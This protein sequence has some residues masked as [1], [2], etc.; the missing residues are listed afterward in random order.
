MNIHYHMESLFNPRN[1]IKHL[2]NTLSK[3][4][5]STTM[6][7]TLT[8]IPG[9]G[10]FIYSLTSLLLIYVGVARYFPTTIPQSTKHYRS[11]DNRLFS[12]SLKKGET[13]CLGNNNFP[14][15]QIKVYIPTT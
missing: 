12:G 1:N 3:D 8:L 10:L 7:N 13:H 15:I 6:I 9:F 14:Y 11:R 4:V 5:A 2:L